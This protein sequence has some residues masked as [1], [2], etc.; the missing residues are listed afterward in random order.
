MDQKMTNE[1]G[2]Q[3]SV[4]H[5]D[6]MSSDLSEFSKDS[7]ISARSARNKKAL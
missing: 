3:A 6:R 5:S 4:D 7:D 2:Q 1:E